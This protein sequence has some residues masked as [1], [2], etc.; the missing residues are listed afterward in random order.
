MTLEEET[1]K[2][3]KPNYKKLEKYGFIKEDNVYKYKEKFMNNEFEALIEIK[4]KVKGQIIDLNTNEEYTNIRL[5]TTGT[6]INKV[7]EKYKNILKKIRENC[8]ETQYFILPQSNRIANFIIN[9]YN[10][11]P[12]FLW[13]KQDGSAVFRNKNNNKWFA[14]I[15]D[16]NKNKIDKENKK[17]EIINTK[18]KEKENLL[19]T[20]GFYEAYH[21]NKKNWITMTL[22]DTLDDEIIIK[23]IEESYNIIGK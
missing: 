19:K 23:Q 11:E 6:F 20:K 7:K 22:D 5:E 10:I 1:F 17:I 9:K 13:K 14:I 21:M 18:I 12:E 8:F 16:I 15:M 4:D 3:T 2:K